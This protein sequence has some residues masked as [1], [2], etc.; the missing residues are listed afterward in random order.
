MYC[1]GG[2]R[3][4]KASVMLRRQGVHDV[5]QLSGGIQRYLEQYGANGYY[6]GLNFTFDKRVAMRPNDCSIKDNNNNNINN[7]HNDEYDTYEVVGRCVEC[8]TPFVRTF[9]F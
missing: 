7:I 9:D 6:K 2:V 5:N 3:C 1:T 8:S 4:E